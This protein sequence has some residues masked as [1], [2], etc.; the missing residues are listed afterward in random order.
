MA[1]YYLLA[2]KYKESIDQT[3]MVDRYKQRFPREV[4]FQRVA[5][6]YEVE[7][8]AYE[9][10]FNVSEDVQY[11]DKAIGTWKRYITHV[12]SN[13]DADKVKAGEDYVAKLEK[14]KGRMQ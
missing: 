6:M 4:Y 14:I 11:L 10:Q 7:A 2:K 12:R 13:G 5:R 8:K 9:G 1:E 3:R